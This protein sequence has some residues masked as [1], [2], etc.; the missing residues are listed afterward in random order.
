MD[1]LDAFDSP[2]V[3]GRTGGGFVR[4]S[5]SGGDAPRAYTPLP[6]S[7]GPK[8]DEDMS[9]VQAEVFSSHW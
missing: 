3:S 6:G 8:K 9:D 5:A 7:R 2:S 4:P 1:F